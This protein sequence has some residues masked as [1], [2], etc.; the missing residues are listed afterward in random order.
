MGGPRRR[1]PAIRPAQPHHRA[2]PLRPPLRARL[3]RARAS[4]RLVP[5]PPAVRVRA[6]RCGFFPGLRGAPLLAPALAG[7]R[8]FHRLSGCQAP[9]GCE[10]AVWTASPVSIAPAA[11]VGVGVPAPA[12]HRPA[13]EPRGG[14]G[15]VPVPGMGSLSLGA[16]PIYPPASLLVLGRSPGV[17]VSSLPQKSRVLESPASLSSLLPTALHPPRAR[18]IFGTGLL[19][20]A[21]TLSERAHQ[22]VARP[23]NDL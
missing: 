8:F 3:F 4:P 9:A 7:T 13:P 14:G 2:P 5:P 1:P 6:R 22:V 18:S 17:S 19:C 15:D 16:R 11:G 12:A 10:D 20:V 23:P 21:I